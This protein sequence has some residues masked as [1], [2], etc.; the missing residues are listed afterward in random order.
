MNIKH[1]RSPLFSMS[2]SH[3]KA[4]LPLSA[5]LFAGLL[6]AAGSAQAATYYYDNDSNTAGFG[7]AGGTWAAPTPG[8]A[9]GWTTNSAGTSIPGSVTTTTNDTL[10]FGNGST[11]LEAGTITVSGTVSASNMTF[12]SGSG[13]IV[14]SGGNITLASTETITV[15]NASNTISSILGGAAT[16]LTK[17]GTGKLTLQGNSSVGTATVSNGTLRLESGTLS[18]TGQIAPNTGLGVRLAAGTLE[19]A[20]GNVSVGTYGLGSYSPDA[21]TLNVTAGSVNIAG[22]LIVGWNSVRTFTVSGG[23]VNAGSIYHRDSNYGVLTISGSGV[24]TASNVY[25]NTASG[26]TDYLRLNL[27]AG[28][29]L[30][31]NQLFISLSGNALTNGTHSLNVNFDGGTLKAGANGMLISTNPPAVS[32]TNA[33]N[34]TV[35]AGGAVIDTNGKTVDIRQPFVHDA[36]LGA[37]PDGGLTKIG[38]GTLTLSSTNTY[39]GATRISAGT[40]RVNAPGSLDASSVVTVT[41]GATL[42]GNGTING[43]VDVTAGGILDPGDSSGGIGMLS[44]NNTLTLDGAKLYVDIAS[45]NAPG[46]TY[47]Q[48]ANT[49]SLVLNGTNTVHLNSLATGTFWLLTCSGTPSGSGVVVFTN[50]TTTLNGA[51]LA[52]VSGGVTMTYT[53]EVSGPNLWKGNV[54]GTWDLSTPN[55]TKDGVSSIFAN[56]ED[57]TF[58]DTAI[59]NTVSGG[60]VLPSSVT[61]SNTTARPYTISAVIG[62]ATPLIKS[63]NGSLIITGSSTFTGD[64]SITGGGTLQLGNSN[65]GTAM[66]LGGGTYAGDIAFSGG[67]TLKCFMIA[68]E[69]FSGII[70]GNGNLVVG[71]TTLTLGTNNTYT[72]TTSILPQKSGGG[73]NLIVSSFNSVSNDVTLGTVHSASSSLGAPTTPAAG[74]IYLGNLSALSD[75]TLTYVG[76]GETTDRIISLRFPGASRDIYIIASGGGLL[77]FTSAFTSAGS[78]GGFVLGGN[79]AGE[80]V[81]GL[82]QLFTP[83]LQKMGNGTWTLSGSN[84]FTIATTISAGILEIGGAGVLANGAYAATIANSATFHF[85]STATQTLSGVISGTGTL[86]KN[87]TG[88]LNLTATSTY[89]GATT[90]SNGTLLVNGRLSGASLVTV[91]SGGTLGGTGT[92]GVVTNNGTLSPGYGAVMGTLTTSNLVLNAGCTNVFDL[93]GTN[94]NDQVAVNGNLTLNGTPMVVVNMDVVTYGTYPLIVASGTAPTAL[95]ALTLVSGSSGA[96]SR[97]AWGGVDNKTLLLTLSPSGTMLIV[98]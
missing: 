76:P 50:G 5:F 48:I 51:T 65:P 95:P 68:T 87:N 23:T 69:I 77:K 35:K 59:T 17:A 30:V 83:G 33:I 9:P 70:S 86:I 3:S 78:G 13:E 31:A 27:N 90:I 55:W 38:A 56:G 74:T 6:F 54:S 58:D 61:V 64:M 1:R 22:P 20:G 75:A 82:P 91:A 49:G 73:G 88:T 12:A 29:T 46:T 37:T 11:G 53:N 67:S 92:V 10:N 41:N 34:V 39:T 52:V 8:S 85:N 96:S 24:V 42:G 60:T 25:E 45:T 2:K 80:I 71:Y 26:G 66:T 36:G 44:M 93:S 81:K 28:G 47:D 97:L 15:D 4:T 16:S 72:G 84:T 21:G 79:G 89:S 19:V 40:L 62:G 7:T 94:A 18:T 43:T 14:L 98:R 57:V 32:S 63:G